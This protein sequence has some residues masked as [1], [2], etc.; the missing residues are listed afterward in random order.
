[1]GK[2]EFWEKSK[3]KKKKKMSV[4]PADFAQRVVKITHVH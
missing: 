3:K 4:L 1:M 2:P